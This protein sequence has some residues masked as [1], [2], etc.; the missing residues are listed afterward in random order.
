MSET[1]YI[2]LIS[3]D[4]VGGTSGKELKAKYLAGVAELAG[5]NA[6]TALA[7]HLTSS[8][9]AIGRY[10]NNRRKK[11]F[12]QTVHFLCYDFDDGTQSSVVHSI[13]ANR[14]GCP[15]NHVIAG[16][17]NHLRDKGD[18]KGKIERFHVF[19]PLETPITDADTYT[20]VWKQFSA[21]DF[22]SLF[23]DP[24][25]KDCS[26]YFARHSQ[27]LYVYNNANELDWTPY[28]VSPPKADTVEQSPR[29]RTTVT[30]CNP[31]IGDEA[32]KA[33]FMESDYYLILR[34][35]LGWGEERDSKRCML[36]G[37]MHKFGISR[38]G[39]HELFTRLGGYGGKF[40]YER[41][42]SLYGE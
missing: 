27:V 38:Q 16:S 12:L 37:V 33:R 39:A 42:C 40:T 32:A 8:H 18:G 24:A 3:P 2:S 5:N 20:T 7:T 41:L 1:K 34:N 25:C 26:R 29:K 13:L 35:G 21:T 4:M 30:F 9:I 36:V 23:P 6:L 17:M 28:N 31:S 19:I 14:R 15:T 10:Q 22:T 11:E